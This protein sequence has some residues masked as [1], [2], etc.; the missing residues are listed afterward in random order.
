M[1]CYQRIHTLGMKFMEIELISL[2]LN[3]FRKNLAANLD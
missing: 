3:E 2:Y 1:T